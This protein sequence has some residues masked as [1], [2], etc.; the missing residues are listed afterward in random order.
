MANENE[1]ASLEIEKLKLERFKVWEKIIT[2][3]I[4]VL[5]GSVLVAYINYSFQK[6]QLEQQKLLRD[7]ELQLQQKKEDAELKIQNAKADADRR[8]A[9]MKYLGDFITYA[10]ADDHEKRLRFAEYF[11]TLTISHELRNKWRA[12]R[13]G[14]IKTINEREAKTIELAAA[15]KESIKDENKIK[16]LEAAI[17]RLNARLAPLPEKSD[18]YLSIEKVQMFLLDKDW[19]PKNYTKNEFE[20]QKDS[21]VIYDKA[22]KLMWQQSGSEMVQFDEARNYIRQLNQEGFAGYNDWRLPTLKE[23]ITL[24]KPEKSNNNLFI[25]AKFDNKQVWIWTSDL[26]SASSTWVVNFSVGSCNVTID[27]YNVLY[28]RAVR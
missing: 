14:I 1:P 8:Q 25:D 23:A 16:N 6:R 27:F 21:K 17:K 12:Y 3:T 28:V 26:S 2:V 11:A 5:F 7:A 9:E 20:V 22:T 10:L 13:N 19:K 18:V 4:T 15:Q 24:L